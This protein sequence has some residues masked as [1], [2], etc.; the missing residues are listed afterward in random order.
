V[1]H[2]L[3]HSMS[4]TENIN[5][6]MYVS[7]RKTTVMTS[8][9]KESDGAASSS[10]QKGRYCS[11]AADGKESCIVSL[12]IKLLVCVLCGLVFGIGLHKA[13]GR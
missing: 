5:R 7:S 10:E 11:L 4:S 8:E 13:H 1:L 6:R 9:Y 2:K 3:L 12:L